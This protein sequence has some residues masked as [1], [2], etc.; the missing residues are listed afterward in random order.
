M[1]LLR[2]LGFLCL[3]IGVGAPLAYGIYKFILADIEIWIKGIVL[4]IILGFLFLIFSAIR[5]RLKEEKIEG[6]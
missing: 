2:S 5:D 3:G 4:L 1:D 6:I